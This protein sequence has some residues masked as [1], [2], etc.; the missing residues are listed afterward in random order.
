SRRLRPAQERD[1]E[2]AGAGAHDA[3]ERHRRGR[4]LRAQRRRVRVLGRAFLFCFG[5]LLAI[6]AGFTALAIG[7]VIEPAARELVAALGIAGLETL[8][9]DLSQDTRPR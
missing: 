7:I 8:L 6:P 1:R 2:A 9:S 4:G 5:V 3:G